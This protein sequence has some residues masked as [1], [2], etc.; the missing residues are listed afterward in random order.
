[1]RQHRGPQARAEDVREGQRV[2]RR[3]V[4]RRQIAEANINHI[5]GRCKQTALG[6]WVEVVGGRER[7]RRIGLGKVRAIEQIALV[8]DEARLNG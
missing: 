3:I 5:R 6:H 2:L 7:A 4:V 1:M 8:G